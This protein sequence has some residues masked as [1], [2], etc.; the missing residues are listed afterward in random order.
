MMGAK[1]TKREDEIIKALHGKGY[2]PQDIIKVLKSRTKESIK[3][4]AYVIGLKWTRKVEID[5]DEF[6][7]LMGAK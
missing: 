3:D 6:K 4:R 7:K 1:F 5:M 2:Q